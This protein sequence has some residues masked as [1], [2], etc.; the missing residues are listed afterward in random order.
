MG[1]FGRKRIREPLPFKVLMKSFFLIS[2]G[3]RFGHPMGEDAE[4]F[5]KG[6]FCVHG[7]WESATQR[8]L[9]NQTNSNDVISLKTNSLRV[10]ISNEVKKKALQ[11][12][13]HKHSPNQCRSLSEFKGINNNRI[14]TKIKG[15]ELYYWAQSSQIIGSLKAIHYDIRQFQVVCC[16]P[17]PIFYKRCFKRILKHFNRK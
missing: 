12:V 10:P 2:R 15:A 3:N 14:G 17:P 13:H 11:A 7:C 9:H 8:P 6:S 1:A 5:R 16:T 4:D